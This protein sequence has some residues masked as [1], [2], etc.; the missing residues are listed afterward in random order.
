MST[1]VEIVRCAMLDIAPMHPTP[2]GV[3]VTTNC[4]YP[5]G[6]FVR[7]TVRGGNDS[8]VVSD[9]GGALQE[10][11]AAGLEWTKLQPKVRAILP[12]ICSMQDGNIRSAVVSREE[13]PYVI[14]AVAN[15][16]KDVA[17]HLFRTLAV[18]RDYDFKALVAAFLQQTFPD[19]VKHNQIFIGASNKA[20]HFDNVVVFPSGAK[21]IVDP[22]LKDPNSC[23]ARMVA[24]FDIKQAH[25]EGLEQR[26]VFDD[27]ESWSPTDINLLTMAATMVP[28]SK[29]EQ[30]FRK[31]VA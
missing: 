18:K 21:L 30:V 9:N 8:F 5:S 13:L 10:V 31:M 28:F 12:E 20:H 26:I 7:V 6:G 29:S 3:T 16:S 19:R 25:I 4:L 24:N 14:V 17:E 27:Q 2:D 1:V 23:N 22:V 15:S 11:D